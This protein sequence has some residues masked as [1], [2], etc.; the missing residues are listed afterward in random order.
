MQGD[1]LPPKIALALSRT[2]IEIA[3][4]SQAA[5]SEGGGKSSKEDRV[6]M[7]GSA[8]TNGLEQGT[9]TYTPTSTVLEPAA[10]GSQALDFTSS[11]VPH[12]A[13]LAAEST[14]ISSNR[15]QTLRGSQRLDITPTKSIVSTEIHPTSSP[16]PQFTAFNWTPTSSTSTI[17]ATFHHTTPPPQQYPTTIP[18]QLS[19]PLFP[20]T[21]THTN[22]SFAQRLRLSS[23]ERGLQLLSSQHPDLQRALF[24][25]LN[26]ESLPLIR[27]LTEETLM[28]LPSITSCGPAPP[29]VLRLPEM[30]RAVEGARIF[31]EDFN[32]DTKQIVERSVSDD[33]ARLAYGRTR[34]WVVTDVRG[35][36]GEWLEPIDVQEYL[37]QKGVW[38][39]RSEGV[40]EVCAPEDIWSPFQNL[41]SQVPAFAQSS[42]TDY[43]AMESFAAPTVEGL[44]TSNPDWT[45]RAI[46]EGFDIVNPRAAPGLGGYVPASEI[47]A[48]GEAASTLVSTT[49]NITRLIE[50]LAMSAVCIGPGP[51]NKKSDVDQ[52]LRV[53]ISGF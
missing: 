27:K 4:Y 19:G 33:L 41:H 43:P 23:V 24:I 37:E 7:A 49:I 2:A 6:D 35:F 22:L 34:T 14:P 5:R 1:D 10:S 21:S 50:T 13:V 39:G 40:V 9:Y 48:A 42:M 47:Y 20:W 3:G 29:T 32:G 17:P 44:N 18:R 25:H 8:V 52:A 15:E 53:A 51:G 38:L 46:W 31:D 28:R 30:Y 16:I 12:F 26:K 36:E 45:T 11:T